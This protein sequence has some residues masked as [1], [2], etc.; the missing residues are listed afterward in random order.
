MI[1]DDLTLLR[2]KIESQGMIYSILRAVELNDKFLV[3]L[4][5]DTSI[6][7]DMGC[8]YKFQSLDPSGESIGSGTSLS[9][10]ANKG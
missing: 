4:I 7:N 6:R 1:L 2:Q 9:C 8:Q 10:M 3:R 5:R